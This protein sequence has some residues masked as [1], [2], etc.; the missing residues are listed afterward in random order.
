[1][2]NEHT[3]V[4]YTCRQLVAA[5]LHCK[6]VSAGSAN[7]ATLAQGASAC[8]DGCSLLAQRAQLCLCLA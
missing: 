5:A 6:C 7:A 3:T 8:R 1:M 4:L 2:V